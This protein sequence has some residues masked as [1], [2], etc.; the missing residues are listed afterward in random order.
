M[1]R[2]NKTNEAVETKII[3]EDLIEGR[4]AV[5]EVLKSDR[6]I[7]YILIAK[8]DMIGSISVVLALAKEKGIVTKEVDRRKLDEMSQTS[9]HQGVIAIVTPYKYFQL[10]DIFKNAEEKGEKP[11]IIIL[12]EIEDPHN[13]GSIIR[14]AEVCGA[15]GIIIPKRKNVGATPTVYKTSA[16][17]IE[18]MKIVKVTNINATI[19]E[20]K[21]RGVWVYG[22]DMDAE[23]YIFNTDLTGAVALVIGSEGRGISKLTKEKCDV[24]VKIPM[25]GKITSLNA[26]VAGGIIMYEIMKQKIR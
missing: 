26:S 9:S 18:H 1:P 24:L 21:Q 7:E 23:N 20:I 11:F 13:F 16:G 19:E 3:R 4:N 10:N 5:I 15:H 2:N 8:G 17:A 6:T 14:T 12:D 22:A 25:I